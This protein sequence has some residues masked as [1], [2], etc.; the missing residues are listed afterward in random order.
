MI[1]EY[2]LQMKLVHVKNRLYIQNAILNS[3][4]ENM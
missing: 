3:N 1:Y 2:I 4:Y